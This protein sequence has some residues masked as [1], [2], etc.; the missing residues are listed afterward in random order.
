MKEEHTAEMNKLI[1][2][3]KRIFRIINLGY[4]RGNY[5]KALKFIEQ[6]EHLI[7]RFQGDVPEEIKEHHMYWLYCRAHIYAFKGNLALCF[8]DAKET[9]RIAQLYDDMRGFS[10]GASALGKYYWLSGDLDKA[11]LHFDRAIRLSEENLN[12]QM[13]FFRL[14]VQLYYATF[15]SIDKEDLERA[16]KYFKRLEEIRELNPANF[17]INEPY[18]GAKALLLK[19]SIRSRDRVM[20]EDLF[21]ELIEDDRVDFFHKLIAQSGLCEL[22]LVELRLSNDINIISEIKP[23]IENLIGMAQTSGLYYFLIEVYILHGKLALIMFDI[24]SSRRYLTQARRMAERHGF[25]GFA[26]EIAGLHEAMMERLDKWEQLEKADA[27]LS[28]RMELA[29]FDDHLK[30]KFRSRIMKMERV[31]EGEVTVYKGSH[32][33][34]VCKGSA[35]GFNF[36]ICPTC[37]TIYCKVCVQAVIDLENQCWSCNS[38]IDA[39]KPVKPYKPI[40]VGDTKE[41]KKPKKY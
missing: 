41:S 16:K 33:C 36:Y 37:N 29:R 10:Y 15:V 5:D 28:E 3:M 26:E 35:G 38:P 7:K 18:R 39:S 6:E 20:S 34:L 31:S 30:G 9:L 8:K 17:F 14:A 27:P 21:R 23:L 1:K 11:L 40:E 25:I 13:D 19:S 24:E 2:K 12:D 32:T 22:L 4:F